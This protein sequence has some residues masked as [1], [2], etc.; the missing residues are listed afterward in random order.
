MSTTDLRILDGDLLSIA[1]GGKTDGGGGGHQDF[2]SR[3]VDNL[4]QDG[5]DWWNREKATAADLKAHHWGS[6]AKNFGGAL[7]DEVGAVG[8]AIAPIKAIK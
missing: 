8:D 1:T 2:A 5:K 4:K 3:Y 6:A 7:L